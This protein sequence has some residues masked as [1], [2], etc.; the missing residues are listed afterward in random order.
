MEISGI[1]TEEI[2]KQIPAAE[3]SQLCELLELL[4]FCE[5]YNIKNYLDE[6]A[7]YEDEEF[8][9]WIYSKEYA[10]IND[11][12]RELM[13]KMSKYAH[14]DREQQ[15]KYLEDVGLCTD[16]KKMGID[17]REEIEFYTATCRKMYKICRSYLR[18]EKRSEFIEDLSFCFPAIYFDAAV[19]GS[20]HTLNRNFSDLQDE[21]VDHLIALNEYRD[22]FLQLSKERKG[23]R[24]V[25]E[26]FQRDTKIEC[27]PQA[28]RDKVKVLK[29]ELWNTVTG[30]TEKVNC[31]LHTKFKKFNIDRTKQDRIYFAPA[32]EG[33]QD[34]KVIVIH[35]GAHL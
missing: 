5:D 6:D 16:N 13:K 28:G 30:E 11:I 35:I 4:D 1:W 29:R 26:E 18:A 22:K 17:F 27:S 3:E 12:K 32:K 8:C 25:A 31:E 20:V 15:R 2:G 10:E 34:G 19:E 21:I 14:I 24:E 9:R 33:I 23:Y 7:I